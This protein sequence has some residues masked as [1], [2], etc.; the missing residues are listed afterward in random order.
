[1]T[2]VFGVVVALAITGG[3]VLLYVLQLQAVDRTVRQ[4]LRTYATQISQ[5]SPTGQWPQPLPASALDSSAQAQVIAADGT[6]LAAT[7]GL[8]GVSATFA[9]PP[10]AQN[11]VR[12][13]AA[14]GVIPGEVHVVA[15][16]VTVAGK[17][18]LIIAGSPVGVKSSLTGEFVYVLIFG[19]PVLF[20]LSALL[21]WLLVGRA[22]KPVTKI[23][24]AVTDITSADLAQRV[25]DPGTTDEIG[26]LA[27]TRND[28]LDRLESSVLRQRRFVADASHELRTPLT[29]IRT[30]LDVA[31]AHADHAPWPAVATRALDQTQRLERLIQDLL[32]LAK[33]DESTGQRPQALIAV[34]TLLS[35]VV[36]STVARNVTLDLELDPASSSVTGNAA[37]LSRLLHNVVENALRY[38]T[39]AVTITASSTDT[40]VHIRVCDD[41]PGVPPE[42]RE[43]V[44][45]R[46]VRL[47][48]S[49]NR[50]SGNSG[51]GLA[52]VRDIA[53]AHGGR[54]WFDE[55]VGAGA[56]VV[57]QLPRD[58]AAERPSGDPAERLAARI[59]SESAPPGADGLMR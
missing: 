11:P 20:L 28:M 6:V 47:D 19:F 41:G 29:A 40:V 27:R 16:R 26:H 55:P 5:G 43:R 31:L 24:Q 54:V 58:G 49:R 10:G 21:V 1:V 9:L 32:V 42:D 34:N 30:T 33:A 18:V 3:I 25:P 45:N 39:F 35:E 4:Q 50:A 8:T 38:A 12:L 46:F 44:F 17:P 59:P 15:L 52:I 13:K 51:L 56:V 23:R 57:I 2:V 53:E 22:L 7:R 36:S 14:D 37:D 48:A